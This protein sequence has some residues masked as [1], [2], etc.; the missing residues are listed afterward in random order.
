MSPQQD[1][2]RALERA[3]LQEA[4]GEAQRILAQARSRA[5]SLRQEKQAQLALEQAAIVARAREE[6]ESL[7]DQTVAEVRV[8]AQS[9]RLR[10]RERLL[11]HAFATAQ[12]RLADA[13]KSTDYAEIADFLV[14]DAARH[15][16]S[17][18][19]IVKADSATAQILGGE[20]LL[21]LSQ[22][23]G[24]RL[25]MGDAL[26]Q[27]TGVILETPDGHRLFDNTLET[28]LR[29]MHDRLRA[30]VFNILAGEDT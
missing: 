9:L 21:S 3:I 16:D 29:R 22:D 2:F 15:I 20:V 18:T 28:R 25:V 12:A 14:R 23:L 11:G 7:L 8:E 1:D 6:A 27:G 30:P 10:R 17:D 19:M 5:S 13:P 24:I 26:A 4:T